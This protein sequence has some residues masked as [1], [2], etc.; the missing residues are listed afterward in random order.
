LT[1]TRGSTAGGLISLA[2]LASAGCPPR[3][4]GTGLTLPRIRLDRPSEQEVLDL[5]KELRDADFLGRAKAEEDLDARLGAAGGRPEPG[6]VPYLVQFLRE[7]PLEPRAAAMRLL[8]R[9][10]R[11]C[12]A[13]ARA[14]LVGAF[15]EMLADASVSAG[16]RS[17]AARALRVW[18]GESF[19][20]RAW[21]DAED[22]AAAAKRWKD[23]LDEQKGYVR[24]RAL[25]PSP[26][27][28]SP[29]RR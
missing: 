16:L 8:M 26:H 21:A 6:V 3:D 25:P 28:T 23:W 7:S 10:G 14:E 9:H 4:E 11:A 19:G 2:L 5:L 1:G 18:T 29:R 17:D 24:F 27:P 20:Y 12:P 13:W 22:R 15:V